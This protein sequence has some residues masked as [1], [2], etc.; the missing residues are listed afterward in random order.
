MNFKTRQNEF[1]LKQEPNISESLK[2][3]RKEL[4]HGC[5]IHTKKIVV[6]CQSFG[7]STGSG[8]YMSE[9]TYIRF[10][11]KR[12]LCMYCS[13]DHVSITSSKDRQSASVH[14]QTSTGT[15]AVAGKYLPP[16]ERIVLL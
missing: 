8:P 3:T 14:M 9:R 12:C 1:N 6:Q 4:S 16:T 2:I 13:G 15:V 11:H 7:H 5:A 10:V